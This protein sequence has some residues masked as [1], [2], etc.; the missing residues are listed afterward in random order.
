M[1]D[2][3]TEMYIEKSAV[4]TKLHIRPEPRR[5][6][7][8]IHERTNCGLKVDDVPNVLSAA[9]YRANVDRFYEPAICEQ[10]LAVHYGI[11]RGI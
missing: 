2:T 9:M 8:E 5:F 7:R 4:K 11:R 3:T 10:C 1:N 6:H